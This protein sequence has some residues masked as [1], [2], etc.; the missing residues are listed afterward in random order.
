MIMKREMRR[1]KQALTKTEMTAV[2]M[3]N[4]SGVLALNGDDGYP[5]TVP[6]SYVY[7]A[8]KIYFHCAKAGYKLDALEHSEKASFCV[9]DRDEVVPE[10]FSTNYISVIAFGKAHVVTDEKEKRLS[11]GL[12]A[13]KYGTGDEEAA[14]REIKKDWNGLTMIRFDIEEMS[15]KAAS[16]V[17]KN[18]EAYFPQGGKACSCQS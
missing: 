10:T 2:L 13:G 3:R 5:Y 7:L 17:I 15:G 16:A 8:G 12:L 11:I 14:E 6:L 4:N 1:G 18:R 9:I